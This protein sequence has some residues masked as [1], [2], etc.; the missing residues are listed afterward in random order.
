M[1]TYLTLQWAPAYGKE[2]MKARRLTEEEKKKY[3]PDYRD[4]LFIGLGER[5][6]LPHIEVRDLPERH[7]DG[8]FLGCS[9]QAWVITQDEWDRYISL[10]NERSAEEKAKERTER[11]NYLRNELAD[12][13][14]QPKLYTREE[15]KAKKKWYN[16]T[17]NEGGGGYVPHFYTIDEYN[18]VLEEIEKIENED[19][20]DT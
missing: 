2:L 10:E 12:M 3:H 7:S 20:Q 11:L 5:V 18:Y 17:Y 13:K 9:N 15:A 6:E 16:D 8:C 19:S 14:N 4:R 1:E